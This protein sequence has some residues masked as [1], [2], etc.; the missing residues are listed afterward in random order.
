MDRGHDLKQR[1]DFPTTL[2][3]ED[4]KHENFNCF[5]DVNRIQKSDL[6]PETIVCYALDLRIFCRDCGQPLEFVG[7]PLGMSYY[8]PTT[9]IDGLEAR[10]PMVVPGQK[11]PEGLASFGVTMQAFEQAG[12]VAQ[13]VS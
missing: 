3:P 7:L 4:C 1:T 13:I 11:V 6:E 10:I 2:K 9:S 12:P 8:R 5:A